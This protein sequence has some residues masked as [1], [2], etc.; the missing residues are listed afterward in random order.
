MQHFLRSTRF[1]FLCTAQTS[2]I[3]IKISHNFA[4]L[5]IEFSMEISIFF[6]K[7]AISHS[8]LDK[9]LSG[10]REHVQKCL[11]SLKIPEILQNFDEKSVKFPKLVKNSIEKFNISILSLGGTFERPDVAELARRKWGEKEE[12]ERAR[13]SGGSAPVKRRRGSCSLCCVDRPPTGRGSEEEEVGDEP[14]CVSLL[15][16]V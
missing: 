6:L 2:K 7:N 14:P 13:R 10:F 1:A 15:V 16:C 8:N 9:I 5:N 3:R 12:V 4:K 11:N